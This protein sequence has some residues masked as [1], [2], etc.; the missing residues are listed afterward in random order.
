M[1]WARYDTSDHE[2]LDLSSYNGI[3]TESTFFL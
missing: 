2:N 1:S 3:L